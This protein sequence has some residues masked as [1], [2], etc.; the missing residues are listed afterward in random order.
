MIGGTIQTFQDG[1]MIVG[2]A[3]EFSPFPAK[4]KRSP[5]A[6]FSGL[7]VSENQCGFS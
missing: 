6:R 1:K 7:F 2:K 5:S 3:I 4:S